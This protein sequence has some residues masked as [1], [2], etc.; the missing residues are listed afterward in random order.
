MVTLTLAPANLTVEDLMTRGYFPD[1][2]IPP[3]N[4]LGLLPAVP[5]IVNFL[6]PLANSMLQKKP[7]KTRSRCV[8]HS[9]SKRKHLRRSLSIPN[10]LHQ[11]LLAREVASHWIALR[12]FCAGSP[13]GLSVPELGVGRALAPKEDLSRQPSHRAQRSIGS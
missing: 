2:V 12:D 3:V 1:R 10:P 8:V 13:F 9:V 7:I 6:H 11:G 4:S 5:D